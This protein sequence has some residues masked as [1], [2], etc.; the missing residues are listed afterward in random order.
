MYHA[1]TSV[2]D[3]FQSAIVPIAEQVVYEMLDSVSLHKYFKNN[4]NLRSGGT[5]VSTS[6]TDT[7]N[8]PKTHENRADI[9]MTFS[10][11]MGDLQWETFK[12]D[13]E[14]Q[15][16]VPQLIRNNRKVVFYDVTNKTSIMEYER[17][18]IITMECK[19][20]FT[21][22]VGAIDAIQQIQSQYSFGVM[23]HAFDHS[24]FIPRGVY[25]LLYKLYKMQPDNDDTL[26]MQYLTDWS[27][28]RIERMINRHD[29][30]DVGLSVRRNRTG[31]MSKIEF[32][33]GAPESVGSEKSPDMYAVNFT[34]KTQMAMSHT[35]GVEYPIAINNK[36]VDAKLLPINADDMHGELFKTHPYFSMDAYYGLMRKTE[37]VPEE[38]VHIPWYDNWMPQH[39]HYP[40]G[41]KPFLSIVVLLDDIENPNGVTSFNIETDLGVELIPEVLAAIKQQGVVAT[42]YPKA[43]IHIAVFRDELLVDPSMLIMDEDLNFTITNRETAYTYR[44]VL[45]AQEIIH[46]PNRTIRSMNIDIHTQK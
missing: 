11:N 44:L 14:H 26:F 34:I 23:E 10:F 46:A 27:G 13:D 28:G 32:D 29:P 40:L 36:L 19:L 18:I 9:D 30:S 5:N 16:S 20:Y 7:T 12:A 8:L 37:A 45:S 42:L 3:I 2:P 25:V 22:M 17:P 15:H 33:Q 1:I 35:L 38:A 31:I 4:I 43:N 6:S 24:Y 21:E 41:Y 39:K